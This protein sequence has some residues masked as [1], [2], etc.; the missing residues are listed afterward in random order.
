MG[1]FMSP[2]DGGPVMRAILLSLLAASPALADT[3]Y[4]ISVSNRVTEVQPSATVEV[5]AVFDEDLFA[6]AGAGFDLLGVPDAGGF[7]D[8]M[9]TWSGLGVNHG[10]VA[11]DGDSVTGIIAGQLNCQIEHCLDQ[12]NP[13]LIWK[14][15]WGTDDF[16]PRQIDVVTETLKF[17]VWLDNQGLS[18]SYLDDL[19]EGWGVIQV[20]CY[21]DCTGDGQTDLFD[22]LC[23]VNLFN[24]GSPG[25]DCDASGSLDLFDFLCFMNQFNEGC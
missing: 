15:T 14:A 4:I 24:A 2:G 19:A 23:F 1:L 21:A 6:F 25:A 5:W 18:R 13:V 20:G 8:P 17:D 10:E 16:A 22:F 12:S 7:S 3:G 11:P 9:G